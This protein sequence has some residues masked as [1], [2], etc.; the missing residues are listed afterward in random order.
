MIVGEQGLH[1]LLAEDGGQELGRHV[2]CQQPLTVLGEH[3]HVPELPLGAHRVERLQEQRPQELLRRNRRSADPRLEPVELGRERR[4]D[5]Q[6]DR[7]QGMPRRHPRRAT[8]L[9]EQARRPLV[10]APHPRLRPTSLRTLTHDN[11]TSAG[12]FFRSLIGDQRRGQVG[13]LHASRCAARE[14]KGVLPPLTPGASRRAGGCAP[15]ADRRGPTPPG[16]RG[17]WRRS[18]S[19]SRARRRPSQPLAPWSPRRHRRRSAR[20]DG[21]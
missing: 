10:A 11:G 6:P 7:P 14:K 18:R 20:D 16:G 13:R 12:P 9:A 21:S 19:R 2:A 8:H 5:D 4:V 15:G 1:P 17:C 3:R